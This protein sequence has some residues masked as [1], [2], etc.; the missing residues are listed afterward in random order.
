MIEGTEPRSPYSAPGRLEASR[1]ADDRGRA[2]DVQIGGLAPLAEGDER[3]TG[4]TS[5]SSLP[6]PSPSRLDALERALLDSG[7]PVI[8]LPL[9]HRFTPG[10]YA[11]EIFMPAGTLL[12]SKVHNTEHFYVVLSGMARVGLPGQPTQTLTAGHVGVTKPGTRRLLYILEDCRWITFHPLSAEE[13]RLRLAGLTDAEMVGAV[14]ERII[15][16]HLLPDGTNVFE[17]YQERLLEDAM[18]AGLIEPQQDY[19]GAP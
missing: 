9:I 14:E 16:K 15:A 19:G 6:A 10:V 11:R 1:E 18:A 2:E 7:L 13:E 8:D 17:L 12:T 5:S 3:A 4:P